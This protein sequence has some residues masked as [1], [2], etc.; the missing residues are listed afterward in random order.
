MAAQTTPKKCDSQALLL[1]GA[2]FPAMG[3]ALAGLAVVAL[4]LVAAAGQGAPSL[5]C[6]QL[7]DARRMR[8]AG[9]PFVFIHIPKVRL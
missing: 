7:E 1:S 8:A 5:A 6:V 3:L 9:A 2:S 4:A